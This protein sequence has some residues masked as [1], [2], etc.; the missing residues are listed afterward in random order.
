VLSRK[1]AC[2]VPVLVLFLAAQG[3]SSAHAQDA[4]AVTTVDVA[5]PSVAK[6][7][8][9]W[10]IGIAGGVGTFSDYPASDNYRVRALPLPYFIYRGSFL[11]ADDEGTRVRAKFSPSFELE[12]SGGGSLSAQSG[13]ISAR[14]GMPDL[15]YLLEAGPSLKITAAKPTTTSRLI[16]DL[17]VRGVIST[18]FHSRLDWR[19]VV[20]DPDVGIEDRSL[21]GSRWGGRVGIGSEIASAPTQKYFYEVEPQYSAAEEGI[22]GLNRPPYQAHGGY[23]ESY[24]EAAV[25]RPLTPSFRVYAYGRFDL[26]GGAENEDSPLF[27]AHTGFGGILGFAW[28][29]WQSKTLADT[30]NRS[31][32]DSG[33]GLR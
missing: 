25:Y 10:E 27:K 2:A 14:E 30:A 20:F 11:R 16:I 3:F 4:P 28:S 8:P 6:P 1:N 12:F 21:L 32:T 7:Q 15:D 13:S 31:F 24:V 5:P 22:A 17:P 29:F 33:A 19:G 23:L 18:N 9:L 26:Y